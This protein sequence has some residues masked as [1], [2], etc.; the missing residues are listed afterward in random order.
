MYDP[1]NHFLHQLGM[2]DVAVPP[3]ADLAM[4]LPVSPQR[5]NPRGGLQGGLLATLVDVTAGRAALDA[6]GEGKTVPTSDLHL[7]FLS[8]VLVGPAVAVATIVRRGR[9]LIIVQVDVTDAGRDDRLGATATL[10][11]SVLDARPEQAEPRRRVFSVR[12]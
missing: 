8:P 12:D 6:A 5:T 10:A 11:F 1:E 4:A 2:V 7:R 9:S 3:G